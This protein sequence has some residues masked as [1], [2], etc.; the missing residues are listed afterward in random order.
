M[1]ISNSL[2]VLGTTALLVFAAPHGPAIA[3][4]VLDRIK[5]SGVM[6]VAT[7]PAWAPYSWLDDTGTWQGFDAAIAEE[8]GKRLGVEVL[9]QRAERADRVLA[10]V[11]RASSAS[12]AIRQHRVQ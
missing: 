1:S 7:D 5:A 12:F 8:I 3:G 4:E 10:A 2:N 11:K 9:H 6:K